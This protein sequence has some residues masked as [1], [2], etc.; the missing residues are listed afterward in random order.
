MKRTETVVLDL[1]NRCNL[2]C[3]MCYFSNTDQLNFQPADRI[4]LQGGMLPIEV[5]EKIAADLFPRAWQVT[6]GCSAEPMLHPR[7]RDIL[8]I[9]RQYKVPYVWFP[10]NLLPLTEKTAEALIDSGVTTVAASIDGVTAETYEKIRIG[11]TFS[12]LTS[13]LELFSEV[14]RRRK[15]KLP[16]LRIIFTWMQA[17]R[18]DL[19]KL[20]A[21]AAEHGASE[22]DVRFVSPTVGV[23]VAPQLL[24][25]EDQVALRAELQEAAHDAVAR[26]LKLMW[27]P[28]FTVRQKGFC[29]GIKN[30]YQYLWRL[31]AG[32]ERQEF[33]RHHSRV[34]RYGCAYPADTWVIRPNGTVL[35]CIFWEKTP[36]GFYPEQNRAEILQAEPLRNIRQGLSSG[37]PIGTC[38]TCVHKRQAL[39][40]PASITKGEA[41]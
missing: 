12:H 18:G 24:L 22:L 26:G 33:W 4:L 36:I 41:S 6:L 9:T 20:P 23:D 30:A 16:K 7:F 29:G 34:K 11:G 38:A 35:P 13:R 3:I 27:Y 1:T 2:K 28:D 19:T 8:A 25:A 5:F 31:R 10:T 37:P 40:K 14:K 32:L 15:S 39:Q 21:F 17:N